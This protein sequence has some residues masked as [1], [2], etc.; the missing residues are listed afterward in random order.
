MEIKV[1]PFNKNDYPDLVR[2]WNE[3]YPEY[4]STENEVEYYDQ[5]EDP[6]T[7]QAKFMAE[8]D[9]QVVGTGEFF[10]LGE[11]FHPRKF[12]IDITVLK[13]F[14]N[15]GVGSALYQTLLDALKPFDPILIRSRVREGYEE[16]RAFLEHKGFK[17]EFVEWESR[18]DVSN[19]DFRSFSGLL[20]SL[21]S[22][23]FILKT[24]RDLEDDPGRDEKLFH[25]WREIFLDV[26]FPDPP[27]GIPFETLLERVKG[28][29]FLPD[30]FFI[31]VKDG[32][33]VGLSNLIKWES[34]PLWTTGLTGVRRD[35]RKKGIA[36]ALK[37]CAI[38]YARERGVPEIKTWNASYN[39]AM[40]SLNQKL[41]FRKHA[42]WTTFAKPLTG[43]PD[44]FGE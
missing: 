7:K 3:A 35:Y 2:I 25:L 27:T 21:E 14:R 11:W 13:Q 1:R 15:Q 29:G 43:K 8:K 20:E 39:Q 30:G 6:R 42:S 16:G 12:F 31:M 38:R 44:H 36:L 22:Q 23:G 40:L 5:H 34:D 33:Y 26:P 41:G 32:E 37:I 28:P 4:G 19:F 24:Y 17:E 9:G 18:L 10:Q